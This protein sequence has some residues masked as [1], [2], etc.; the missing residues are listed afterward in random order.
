MPYPNMTEQDWIKQCCE[1]PS[2]CKWGGMGGC[3]YEGRK[4]ELVQQAPGDPVPYA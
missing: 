2:E 1:S 3:G 4:A